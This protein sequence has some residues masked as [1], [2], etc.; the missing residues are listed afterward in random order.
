VEVTSLASWLAFDIMGVV[1]FGRSFASVAEGKTH[2]ALRALHRATPV[3]GRLRFAPWLVNMLLKVPGAS[4]PLDPF[5]R[6]CEEML[7]E[8][9]A[10]YHAHKA[11][12]ANEWKEERPKDVMSSFLWTM[13]MND[14]GAPPTDEA[15]GVESRTIIH[16][17]TDNTSAAATNALWFLAAHPNS[18]KILQRRL[19][20]DFPGGLDAFD[21]AKMTEATTTWLDAIIYE[22]MR[23]RPPV[24]SWIPRATGPEGLVIPESEYGPQICVPAHVEIGCP[25]FLIHR[26]SRWFERPKEFL[27]ERWLPGSTLRCTRS[28]WFPFFQGKW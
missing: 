9:Q 19:D 10:E 26:D 20:T 5:I 25:P 6:T 11:E 23:L 14:P 2:P 18:L 7:R 16:A 22:T 15:L 13:D 3:I 21:Y 1:G 28:A 17:G 24:L 27:P 8:S 12:R 4:G